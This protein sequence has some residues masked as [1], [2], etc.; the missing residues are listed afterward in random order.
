MES[1][2]PLGLQDLIPIPGKIIVKENGVIVQHYGMADHGPAHAHVKGGGAETKIGPKGHPLKNQPELSPKQNKVIIKNRKI[3]RKELNKLGRA[4]M[5]MSGA[6]E[7][8]GKALGIVGQVLMIID[9][10]DAQRRAEERGVD[11]W[12][13]MLE[14][15]DIYYY[16]P[17][18]P[19]CHEA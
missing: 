1:I 4:R 18:A 12:T 3:I 11:V 8:L 16:D 17:L 9:F 13:I 10:F 2:D 6:G 15:M 14:D 19:T 7:A 5:R